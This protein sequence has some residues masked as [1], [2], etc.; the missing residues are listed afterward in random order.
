[1]RDADV[2]G[3]FICG[4][5]GAAHHDGERERDRKEWKIDASWL[6]PHDSA[7]RTSDSTW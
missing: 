4:A 1:V 3:T 5:P 7:G 2:E 6:P